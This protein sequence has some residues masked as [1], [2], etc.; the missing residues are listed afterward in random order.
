MSKTTVQD[1]LAHHGVK[2]MKWGVRQ[3]SADE[4]NAAQRRVLGSRDYKNKK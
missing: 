3:L 2:G 4:I 1:V